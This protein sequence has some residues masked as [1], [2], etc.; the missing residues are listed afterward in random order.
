[1]G[2]LVAPGQKLVEE[3]LADGRRVYSSSIPLP[4]ELPDILVRLARWAKEQ[5]DKVLLS[6][7][8]EGARR[9]I[10][11]GE[12]L[13][14]ARAM[15]QLLT[16]RYGLR[17][18]DCVATLAPAGIDALVLKLACL[19]GGFVHAALPPFPFR[20]GVETE[21]TR[22]FLENARPRLIVAP[23]GHPAIQGMDAV[24]LNDLAVDGSDMATPGVDE[25]VSPDDWAAIFFTS[26]STGAPKGVPITR[27]MVSSNQAAIAAMWPFV[28]E[29]PPVLVDWLPWHHVFGGLDNIFKVIWNGGAMHVDAAPGPATIEATAKLMAD[30][31]PTMHIAVPLGLRLLLDRLEND[32][33]GA[34]ALTRRLRAI[35]FAGAGIDAD[36]WRRLAAFRDSH[37][38]FQILSGYGATEAASTITLSPAPLER[39][40]ELGHP[41]PGHSV[42]LVDIDGRSELRVSGP[43]IAPCY[44]IE[45]RKVELPMDEHG[46]YRTGDAAVLRQRTDGVAVFGFDGRLAEDFKLSSGVKVRTGPLRAGLLAQCAPLADDIVI[47]GENRDRLVALVF[48]SPA[49]KARPNELSVRI[50]AWN[51]ANPSGSTAIARFDLATAP[52][53]RS[54]GEQSDK[55]QIVQSRYLRNHADLFEALH[56]GGGQAPVGA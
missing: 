19:S 36:L 47:S 56:A 31:C 7:P 2:Q 11:Y 14:R 17:K 23:S 38:D 6:E 42:A 21:A 8:R 4:D 28:V 20:D 15:R 46:F 1:M 3:Q 54:K 44:L 32:D 41:L 30:V 43:N 27:G 12:A 33:A 5:P 55:G 45:G 26:G 49:G 29:T 35:F 37:G 53:D 25:S 24:S 13:A 48:P 9:S 34:L 10:S 40:G 22:S 16:G 51:A 18:G 52:A 39:P 50:A